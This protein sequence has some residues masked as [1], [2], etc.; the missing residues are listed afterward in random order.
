MK[1]S[2]AM[3]VDMLLN[4]NLDPLVDDPVEWIYTRRHG[5]TW[6]MQEDILESIRDNRYTA[7]ASAH[8]I[9]KSHIASEAVLWWVDTHPADQVFVVTTAPSVPQIKAILWR[10]IKSGHRALDMPEIGRAH[11]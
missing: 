6:S 9:G 3:A 10:Y 2:L 7:V 11:V 1:S 4:I 8:S 5:E